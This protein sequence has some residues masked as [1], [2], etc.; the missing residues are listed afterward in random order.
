MILARGARRRAGGV[1]GRAG[2]GRRAGRLGRRRGQGRAG[3]GRPAAQ[4]SSAPSARGEQASVPPFELDNRGKRSVVLDLR[5]RRRPG[6]DGAACS[7]DADVFVTNMRVAALARLG[8][9]PPAVRERHP[10]ADLR[11]HHRLRAGGSRRPP[12]RLRRRRV[13][14]P[15]DAGRRPSCRRGALPPPIR[16]GFG[17][18]VTGMTLAGGICGA[19]FDRERTG[20][21]APRVDEPAAD[22]AVLRR[23]GPRRAAALRQAGEHPRPPRGARR[24]CVN[25]YAAADGAGFWLLGLEADRHWPGAGRRAR[26]AR[27][28]RRRALRH[29]AGR[30][31][32]T[33]PTLIAELDV[34]F[35]AR[36]MAEWA[37]RFDAPRRLVGAD[38]HAAHRARRPA[39]RG[40]RRV[41]RDVRRRRRRAVPGDR[42]PDRLRRRDP[43]PRPG[44]RTRRAHRR[45]PRPAESS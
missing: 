32:S 19:L 40:V 20:P 3:V 14:G 41:R 27:P 36:P 33:A 26:P 34:A 21:R 7:A 11:D 9:D 35:A 44:P 28:G 13:L 12:P 39:G 2:G 17:D 45:G 18:H 22:R 1:G 15:L 23:L 25:C 42:Q 8:L 24:R 29:G 37:E 6:G 16:G 4:R 10:V 43:A 30:G 31:S 38:Q 5:S